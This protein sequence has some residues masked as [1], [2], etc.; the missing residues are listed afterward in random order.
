ME[1]FFVIATLSGGYKIYKIKARD[2]QE[3][4]R[5]V[6]EEYPF[7]RIIQGIRKSEIVKM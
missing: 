4:E 7:L 3:A 6:K 2:E 1:T 5:R